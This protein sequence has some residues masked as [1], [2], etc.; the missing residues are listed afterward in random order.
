L[1]VRPV[2]RLARQLPHLP[3][4][5]TTALGRHRIDK[6][7]DS[8]QFAAVEADPGRRRFHD[9]VVGADL[10]AS[11]HPERLP[12]VV[13]EVK[14]PAAIANVGRA[15]RALM[16]VASQRLLDAGTAHGIIIS[17]DADTRVA[18][19]WLAATVP[20]IDAGADAVGGRIVT[21]VDD[22]LPATAQRLMR[23]DDRYRLWRERLACLI[24]PDPG[25]PWPRHHQHF[26][27]SLAVTETAY[28]DRHEAA[29]SNRSSWLCCRWRTCE[30]AIGTPFRCL[31]LANAVGRGLQARQASPA[32]PAACGQTHWQ[33]KA[34]INQNLWC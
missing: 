10:A 32:C 31:G 18:T 29:G 25:D 16:D 34:N 3:H 13:V 28:L 14:W 24:D 22:A 7:S 27:A 2:G 11:V 21:E 26:G 17:T 20:A 12:C 15:R 5:S 23:L 1:F 8:F 19:D 30:V 6:L 9:L 4:S 33:C